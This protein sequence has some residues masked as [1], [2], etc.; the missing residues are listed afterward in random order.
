MID[1]KNIISFILLIIGLCFVYCCVYAIYQFFLKKE[2]SKMYNIDKMPKGFTIK[3]TRNEYNN[4]NL[5]YPEWKFSNKNGTKDK[6]RK[7]NYICWKKNILQY[8]NFSLITE[9]PYHLVLLV[10]TLRLKNP[11]VII[12]MNQE[13]LKKYDK[14]M[15]H[16]K[17]IQDSYNIQNIV[18]KFEDT[19][20]DFENFSAELFKKMGYETTVTPKT[21]DGGFDIILNKNNI[22]TLVECKCYKESHKIGRPI[23]QKLVGANQIEKADKMLFITT[24]DFSPNAITYAEELSVEL[25][26][27]KKLLE[28]INK[29]MTPQATASAL[30][31]S[32]WM[33]NKEDICHYMP[34]DIID[35]I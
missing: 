22:K 30:H 2:F 5:K 16:K 7:N 10:N 14:A 33:L 13:E 35:Y 1:L 31:K 11:Q 15:K 23:I 20:T 29:Y 27:G 32:E 12:Q 18:K 34:K 3:R 8:E 24:S 21:N 6:R 26:N 28:L 9:N 4:Y 19:P 25:I 17:I